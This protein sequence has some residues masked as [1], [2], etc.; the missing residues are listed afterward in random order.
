M[1]HCITCT[2]ELIPAL[3]NDPNGQANCTCA[4]CRAEEEHDFDKEPNTKY[5]RAGRLIEDEK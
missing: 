2:T 3:D 1:K 4:K 5:N